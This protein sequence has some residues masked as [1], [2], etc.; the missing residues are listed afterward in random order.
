MLVLKIAW[1]NIFRQQRRSVLT[2]LTMFG[3]FTLAAVS[4]GWADGTYNRI[5]NAFTRNRLGH[6]QIHARGYLDRPSIQD[7]IDNCYAVGKEV[8][9]VPGVEAWA[10]RF[11]AAG[12]ASVGDS[13]AGMS[14]IGVD[15]SLES[16]ATG[17]ERKIVEGRSLA[18]Q[19]AHE[20]VLGK[21]LGRR[22][23]AKIADEVVIVSQ[24]ADGSIANDLY[25]IV[26]FLESGDDSADQSSLYLHLAD[27]QEL[28]ALKGAAHEIVII[29]ESLNEVEHVTTLIRA[30]LANTNLDVE[31]WQ[32]FA[33]SFYV[34]MQADK[35][36]N[37]ILQAI[38]VLIVGVG[39]L[40]TVLMTVLERT[41]EYGVL[42]AVGTRASVLFPMIV[43]EVTLMAI[44]SIALGTVASLGANYWLS[45][46]GI[47]LPEPFTYGGMEFSHF[48]SEINAH[49]L[50][51]PAS[52]ILMVAVLV[53][54][55][56]ALRACRIEPARALRM[57]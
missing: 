7:R 56:P 31:P 36:G 51:I 19:S 40:N 26:G 54:L 28:F 53:S 9:A 25:K 1:R 32:E 14:V 24:A 4:I 34:A 8:S 49:S 38:I 30:A 50:Y 29:V 39:V 16:A 57:H 42:R 44:I 10:P 11:L 20:A 18:E 45:L 2:I 35:R 43:G 3:G 6:I 48:Y 13:T 5:I 12:L 33:H 22:L 55:Y 23:K 52:T 47:A 46:H 41:R 15:P 17:F 37:W 21:G 27:A